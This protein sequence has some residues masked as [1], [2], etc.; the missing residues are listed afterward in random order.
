MA[1]RSLTTSTAPAPS[2]ERVVR[3]LLGVGRVEILRYWDVNSCIASTR[4]AIEVLAR[5]GHRALPVV[6][7]AR[8]YNRVA[9][10][11]IESGHPGLVDGGFGVS[12][13]ADAG[14]QMGLHLIALLD[15]LLIDLSLDQA[16][17][18]GWR[19]IAYPSV[20]TLADP[21]GFQRGTAEAWFDLPGG[22]AIG[23][24]ALRGRRHYISSPAWGQRDA[25]ARRRVA[26]AIA[27]HLSQP[28]SAPR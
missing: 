27:I 10:D 24:R 9:A 11:A 19:L 16:S 21:L 3:A 7:E 1:L 26:A 18:P 4:I 22:G 12:L 28:P 15:E 17:R 6:V 23:Y 8:A 13:G 20:F 25:A 14:E 5:Y 2:R